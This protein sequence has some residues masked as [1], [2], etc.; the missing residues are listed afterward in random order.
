MRLPVAECMKDDDEIF[1]LVDAVRALLLL[2]T[3]SR[4]LKPSNIEP[5]KE[6]HIH[7][8]LIV[9]MTI[10]PAARILARTAKMRARWLV[11]VLGQG[12]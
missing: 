7:G 9:S 4:P 5:I 12:A 10:L 3:C 1:A 2:A 11:A 6:E 8:A